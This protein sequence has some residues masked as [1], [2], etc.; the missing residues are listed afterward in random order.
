MPRES[1]KAD[2]ALAALLRQLREERGKT[3][4]VIA[5]HAGITTASLARIELGQSNPTW[6]TVR[7]IARALNVSMRD[8][9]TAV[10]D[11]QGT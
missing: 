6:S 11:A 4:E 3:Q 9:G 1:E 2:K 10:D 5:F 7:Q 8:L